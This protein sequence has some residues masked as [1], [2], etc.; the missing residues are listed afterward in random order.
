MA[1]AKAINAA[2]TGA[3]FTV[4]RNNGPFTLWVKPP[5]LSMVVY[6]PPGASGEGVAVF[7]RI[8]SKGA[9]TK[10]AEAIARIAALL[11]NA[12]MAEIGEAVDVQL[13]P[14]LP[15]SAGAQRTTQVQC[16]R[17]IR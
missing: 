14:L 12:T 11:D 7:F 9:D 6:D 17:P 5:G 15:A 2:L 10:R 13:A 16:V 8:D 4:R 1:D 3:G